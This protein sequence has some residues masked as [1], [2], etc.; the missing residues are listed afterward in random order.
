MYP[1]PEDG[2]VMDPR[3]SHFSCG[4][5]AM[6]YTLAADR[7]A[8]SISNPL[9]LNAMNSFTGRNGAPAQQQQRQGASVLSG[10]PSTSST[11]VELGTPDIEEKYQSLHRDVYPVTKFETQQYWGCQNL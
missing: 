6:D 11:A 2:V 8:S 4:N 3:D 9:S 7:S 5:N 1:K 10:R